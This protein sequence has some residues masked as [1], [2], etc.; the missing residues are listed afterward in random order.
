MRYYILQAI[1]TG[2]GLVIV[3]PLKFF[4]YRTLRY[5]FDAEG[6]T[7]R[8]G[9]LFRRE[10]SL[11]YARIQ[12]IHLVSNVV[13][14][15]LG[16]G[17]V[18]VQTASGQAGAEMTIEGLPDFEEIRNELYVRMRGARGDGARPA[19]A[20]PA[21]TVAGPGEAEAVAAALRD[22]VAELRAIRA[23]IERRP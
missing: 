19:P 10:I 14:R 9:I 17:R 2:P 3:L 20:A 6:M 15:W 1:A 4:R 22:A 16:L 23:L 13:E 7:A 11:T 5:Q 12:D 21:G 8:W 18:Q